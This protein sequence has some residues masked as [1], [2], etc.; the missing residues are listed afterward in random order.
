MVTFTS[1]LLYPQVKTPQYPQ[2]R[3]MDEPNAGL[4]ILEK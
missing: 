4:D 2:N 1:Q 3:R